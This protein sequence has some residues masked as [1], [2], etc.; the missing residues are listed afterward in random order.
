LVGQ[1][2]EALADLSQA[3]VL[4]GRPDAVVA[5][6]LARAQELNGLYSAADRD[7]GLAISMTSNEVNP[8]WLRAALVKL[9]LG[10]VKGGFDLLKR[11]ENR[12]PEAPEV[13]AAY[14]VFLF[15]SG[16]QTAAQQKYL[17]IPDRARANYFDSKYL[18]NVIAWP[19]TA[20]DVLSKIS[21]VAGDKP[22]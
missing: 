6:N 9:Q 2:K 20:I 21:Q 3:S 19:P 11:V 1:P 7:Y 14:S 18:K 4:R 8:F 5:Q 12:F 10:D 16:D 13:R 17:E 22:V 15:S